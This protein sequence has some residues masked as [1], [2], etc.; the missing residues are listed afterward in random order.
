[1]VINCEASSKKS[2]ILLDEVSL[3]SGLDDC[4]QVSKSPKLPDSVKYYPM[5]GLRAIANHKGGAWRLWVLARALDIPGS[6]YISERVFRSSCSQAGIA[7]K[8]YRRW[9][10]QAIHIGILSKKK[11]QSGE[12]VLQIINAGDAAFRLGC[13]HVDPKPA[14]IPTETLING[15][16]RNL[17]WEAFIENNFNDRTI[18]REA[19]RKISGISRKEQ[20]RLEKGTKVKNFINVV[21]TDKPADHLAGMRENSRATAFA[22]QGKVVYRL[23]DRRSVDGELNSCRQGRTRT[24]NRKLNYLSSELSP[25]ETA[26]RYPENCSSMRLFFTNYKKMERALR[27][28]GR[29]DRQVNEVY[30]LKT[31]SHDGCTAQIWEAY[32]KV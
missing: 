20:V 19:L 24:I 23:P 32:G 31:A 21:C 5:M 27:N 14:L 2:I 9:L 7:S 29:H 11:R 30:L 25:A 1:L 8:T 26:L 15:S 18:S 17:V 10:Q 16:W 4:Q 13:V 6:G 28:Y 12:T 22:H 3:S